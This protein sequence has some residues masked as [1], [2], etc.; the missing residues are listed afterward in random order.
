M[1]LT[2][3]A[4]TFYQKDVIDNLHKTFFYDL[5]CV[6]SALQNYCI[7]VPH[8]RCIDITFLT[9]QSQGFKIL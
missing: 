7:P 6:L 2:T 1:G 3:V 9:G 5:G 4:F 8:G